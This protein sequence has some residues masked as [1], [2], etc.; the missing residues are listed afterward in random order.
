M[1]TTQS[2]NSCRQARISAVPKAQSVN[3]QLTDCGFARGKTLFEKLKIC[4]TDLFSL[5]NMGF[6]T[7]WALPLG[8][9]AAQLPERAAA[10]WHI[11]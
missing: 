5:K 1:N 11:I 8:E 7:N 9:L 10:F 3:F 6:S 4:Q 2:G